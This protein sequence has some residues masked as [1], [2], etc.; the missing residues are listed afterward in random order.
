MTT[1]SRIFIAWKLQA[2]KRL[3]GAFVI[4]N[5]RV[6]RV[7]LR[8][9]NACVKE[10]AIEADDGGPVIVELSLEL[11]GVPYG[12]KTPIVRWLSDNDGFA[13]LPTSVPAEG[14]LHI[15]DM[16]VSIARSLGD[17]E[18]LN[19]ECAS[20]EDA[21]N[22][23]NLPVRREIGW[24][25]WAT[26]NHRPD[27]VPTVL[28][29]S[30]DQRTF[31]VD[32]G[33]EVITASIGLATPMIE[34][35]L[36][37]AI[38]ADSQWVRRLED[39][40]LP[41]LHS[42]QNL[43][44]IVIDDTFFASF[45]D[46]PLTEENLVGTPL[47]VCH[48]YS[49]GNR[50]APGLKEAAQTEAKTTPDQGELVLFVRSRLTNHS[51]IPLVI[52]Q[53]L[54]RAQM[55]KTGEYPQAPMI[56]QL[57]RIY[58]P[59]R[60]DESGT[61]W[62]KN[63]AFALHR[64][65]GA[66]PE[67]LQP[68]MMIAPGE[69][70]T[71]ESILSHRIEGLS[72][73]ARNLGVPWEEKFTEAKAF[74]E[75]KLRP[76]ATVSLPE[77]RLSD[78]W[79]A[80]L[81]HL[82]LITLGKNKTGALLPKVGVYTAI[83]SESIPIVEFYDSVGLHDVARRCVDS[84]FEF[85]EAD[86]RIN[87]YSHYDI[88][89]G[90]VLF[91]A[92]RH[93][94][95]TQDKPWVSTKKQCLKLAVNYLLGKRQLDD[96][97]SPNYGLIAGTCADPVDA[98][99]SFMLNAYNAAGFLAVAQMLEAI[100]DEEADHYRTVAEEFALMLR[101]AVARSFTE[102]PVVP[103][104]PG[105]WVPTCAPWV[106]GVGLQVLGLKGEACY[107]HRTHLAFDVLLGPLYAAFTG[108]IDPKGKY[109]QWLL[110]VNHAQLNRASVAESQ[111]YYSRHPEIHLLRGERE[112]FLNAFYSG[113]TS[114]SDWETFS[115]WEHFHQISI[116]KTHEEGWALMQL[117]RMLWLESGSE[118]HLLAGIPEDWLAH[119]NAIE[120][121]GGGSYFG[122]ISF[123]LERCPDGHAMNLGWE[124]NFHTVPEK[125]RLCLPGLELREL[126]DPRLSDHSMGWVEIADPARP[127]MARLNLK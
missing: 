17:L 123:R 27:S 93:F 85:Q 83:G 79:K 49:S 95:Y 29:L 118:L 48:L 66:V 13:F 73:T 88:E 100:S 114:L 94:A 80:G 9:G 91:L 54:P 21:L 77:K 53:R 14:V 121:K 39:G 120:I 56:A 110:E 87:P 102:G 81:S 68:A 35:A 4:T 15:P 104:A 40:Y 32:P 116:H 11:S 119:E 101:N 126:Q 89:T 1:K 113:L 60:L 12:K 36:G 33:A 65:N 103:T 69:S 16:G 74:W 70:M 2:D 25:T 97:T 117:R 84:F 90:A 19:P 47:N 58:D 64:V 107:S 42:R 52:A 109:A 44:E 3:K 67:S 61:V 112:Q 22:N 34:Y 50:F 115:F 43:G 8:R 20:Y 28:G 5:G 30:R 59:E 38:T 6:N 86:G 92:E 46:R 122:T 7:T 23:G 105:R 26:R 111:P 98:T 57:E 72:A 37:R 45:I 106:E 62:I 78:F 31:I 24:D 99:T 18:A 127:L 82:E 125:V 51:N 75:Q 108:I 10:N 96:P 71:I 63:T 124:P 55:I 76:A 41:I